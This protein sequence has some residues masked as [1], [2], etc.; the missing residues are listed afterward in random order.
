MPALI[1]AYRAAEPQATV[2]LEVGN[3]RQV[4]DALRAR[5][6]DVGVGGRAPAPDLVAH[7][8]ADNDLVVVAN[9]PVRDLGAATWLLREQ[10][11]GTRATLEA[12]LEQRGI[13]PRELLT[14]GSNGAIRQAL[15]LGLGVS[16]ISR[17]AVAAELRAGTL[18]VLEAPG[19]P[20]HRPFHVLTVRSP[21]PRP[22]AALLA[23]FLRSRTARELVAGPARQSISL[24]RS[25]S[26]SV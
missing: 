20:L 18:R 9:G 2:L 24:I 15:V 10:G 16:L 1:A 25:T 22:A 26:R 11:S 17:H 23:G 19:T 5:R 4:V 7:R 14:L 21:P 6:A 3:R 13:L 8:L 12:Y